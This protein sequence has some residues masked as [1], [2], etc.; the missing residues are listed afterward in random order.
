MKYRNLIDPIEIDGRTVS[1]RMVLPP[2]V[3]WQSDESGKVNETHLT[4][5]RES[6]GPGILIVEATAVSKEGR[7]SDRQLGIFDDSQIPGLRGLAQTIHDTGA[8]AG[9]QIHH[10]GMKAT[11]KT[12]YGLAPAAPSVDGKVHP[13]D[14]SCRELTADEIKRIQDDFA[15]GAVRAADAGFDII[16]LHGAHGY[17]INQFLSPL[18]N[19]RKDRYGGSR[20][21][22]QRFL[23]ETFRKCLKVLNGRALLSCRLGLADKNSPESL[24]EGINT[25]ER[26]QT[27]GAPLLH[28]SHGHGIYRGIKNEESPFSDL[29]HLAGAAGEAVSVPVIGVGNI[30][31]PETADSAIEKGIADLVAAGRAM[32][33]DPEWAKKTLRGEGNKINRC[34]ECSPCHWFEDPSKCPVRIKNGPPAPSKS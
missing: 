26:L 24:E 7:L 9:I 31:D 12:T 15:K 1:N 34:I 25:A 4:H 27:E 17:L 16:E 23:M 20:E 6:A 13:A 18:S 5:Y 28:I 33:S 8:L 30:L 3:I 21:N 22:R 11:K 2:M 29:M 14:K 19:T 10:A 32:L